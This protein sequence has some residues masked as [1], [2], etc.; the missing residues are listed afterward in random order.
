VLT[1]KKLFDIGNDIRQRVQKK[2]KKEYF[3]ILVTYK[4]FPSLALSRFWEHFISGDG[5]N[6]A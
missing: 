3:A 2:K 5:T 4:L 6:V 1:F